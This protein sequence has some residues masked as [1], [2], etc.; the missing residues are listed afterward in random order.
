MFNEHVD[1]VFLKWDQV[2]KH[3]ASN[4]FQEIVYSFDLNELLCTSSV[5]LPNRATFSQLQKH[6]E[7]NW[8]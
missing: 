3:R 7:D 2:K 4:S 8:L 5:D 6:G 1:E